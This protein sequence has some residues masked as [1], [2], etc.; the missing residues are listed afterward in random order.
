MKKLLISLIILFSAL[1]SW[2]QTEGTDAFPVDKKTKLITFKDVVEE[3]GTKDELFVRASEWLHHYFKQPVYVTNVRDAASGIIKGK[4]QFEL[5]ITDDDEKR[6]IGMIKY[7]FKIECRDGRYRYILDNF[8]LTQASKFPC[9]KWLDV[10]APN[11][12]EEMWPLYLEEIRNYALNDFAAS[13][14]EYMVPEEEV[15]EEE[16]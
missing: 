15:E 1:F 5:F 2:A 12:D 11:Y 7:Y 9:E 13:L 3:E 4:H 16:W 6:R 8:V 10:T 14:K